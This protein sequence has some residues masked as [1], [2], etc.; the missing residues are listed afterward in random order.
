[1]A[2]EVGYPFFPRLVE[3]FEDIDH[4]RVSVLP[5]PAVAEALNAPVTRRLLVTDVGWFE[6]AG[7]H[8]LSRPNGA[9]ESIV[10]L[11]VDGSG[12]VEVD[13]VRHGIG[14]GSV[15]LIPS[16]HPHAYGSSHRTPWTIWWC[17]LRG[18][19]V[20]ELFGATGATAERP[21]ISLWSPER[22]VALI[23]EI[24]S[25]LTRDQSPVRLVAA[26]GAA[27]KL[28]T[29]IASDRLSAARDDPLQR[30]LDYLAERVD[31]SVKVADLAR[32]VG[33]SESRLATLVRE[34]TGGGVLAHHTALR[35]ARARQ[36]LDAGP[37]PIAEVAR[38]LGYDDPLYFSRVFR[39]IHGMSPS[40]YRAQRK[41]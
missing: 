17:H 6:R 39:R 7:H 15:A 9:K 2:E 11:C 26:T 29:Q 36:L 37:F 35:M 28:M 22:C 8:A 12:W 16:P 14:A 3:P 21:V 18:N 31:S 34:A 1:M 40:E 13:G 23:D 5:R 4:P 25:G 32:L 41:G 10:I 19:D 33:M 30:A 24:L 38:R 27:F 20:P